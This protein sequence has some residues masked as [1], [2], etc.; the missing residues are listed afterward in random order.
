LSG[1]LIKVPP[2]R[3]D[4]ECATTGDPAS[5]RLERASR[6][7]GIHLIPRANSDS[8]AHLGDDPIPRPD[9]IQQLPDL[10]PQYRKLTR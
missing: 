5:R 1:K 3:P 9:S 6:L 4:R 8:N 2:K 10:R 7:F